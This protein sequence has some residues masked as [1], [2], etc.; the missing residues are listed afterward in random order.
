MNTN[1]LDWIGRSHSDVIRVH[2]CPFVVTAFQHERAATHFKKRRRVAPDL[3]HRGIIQTALGNYE[4]VRDQRK[5]WFQDWQGARQSRGAKPSGR[6]SIISTQHLDR[7]RAPSSKRAARRFIGPA[8]RSRRAT[9]SSASCA[10]RTR[11]VIVKSKAMTSEEIHLNDALEHAG[12]EVVESDLG[13]FIVQL[14]QEPPYHIVFP[15][16]HLTRGEIS[17]LFQREARRRAVRRIPRS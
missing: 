6:R 3:R 17:E 12:Y 8:P 5:P 7:V 4:V 2:S 9:S 11:K 14:R 10:R 15:A 1:G 16:M 13:E